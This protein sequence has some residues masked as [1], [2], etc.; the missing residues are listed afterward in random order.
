[1]QR[2]GRR[3]PK[4][5]SRV[6]R[7][8][9]DTWCCFVVRE[10]ETQGI[11]KEQRTSYGVDDGGNALSEGADL[12]VTL[13]TFATGCTTSFL[14]EIAWKRRFDRRFPRLFGCKT[15]SHACSIDEWSVTR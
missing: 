8:A 14:V 9:I 11:L 12:R 6:S 7:Q 10:N 5:S 13:E 15:C 1:M 3:T 4:K 2:T